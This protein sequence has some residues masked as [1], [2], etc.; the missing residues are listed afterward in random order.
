MTSPT[1]R[2]LKQLRKDGWMVAVVEKWNPHVGIRQD[3]F[4]FADLLAVKDNTVLL[5]QCTSGDNV[6]ARIKKIQESDPAKYWASSPN[7]WIVVH[8]WRMVG[9]KGKRKLWACREEW[10]SPVEGSTPMY[11]I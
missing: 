5:V 6:A 9:A 7:R 11:R 1:Q 3:L 2:S 4:G 10:I 8:G